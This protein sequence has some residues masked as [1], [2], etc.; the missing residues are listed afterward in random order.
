MTSHTGFS[1]T[2]T[3]KALE[4]QLRSF[5]IIP[6]RQR[7]DIAKVLLSQPQH[8]SADQVQKRLAQ[9]GAGQPSRATVYNTLKLFAE[10]GLVRE[11]VVDPQRIF[12]D[13]NREAH[14]HYFNL[15][16]GELSDIPADSVQISGLPEMPA[17]FRCETVDVIVRIRAQD[18][19]APTLG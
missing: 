7:M 6:T 5:G 17:G 19:A 2:V 9:K 4:A 1:E 8:L 13:S 15:D 14:H 3:L 18:R 10:Q 11:V 16:T 12:F